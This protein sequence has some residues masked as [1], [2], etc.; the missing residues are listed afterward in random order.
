[1]PAERGVFPGVLELQACY[2]LDQL[3]RWSRSLK[4]G[5][6]YGT[7]AGAS[8]LNLADILGANPIY[9]LGFDMTGQAG[10]TVNWHD[11]YKE[12]Q[13]EMV[14]KNFAIDF[15]RNLANIRSK[16]V[17][18]NPASNLKCFDF[19]RIEDVIPCTIAS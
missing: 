4:E 14:Y 10:K 18:L 8:A 6:W 9:L 13:D 19:G 2:G 1:M 16:V 3:P 5:L 15:V 11:E 7:N 12:K 17:N